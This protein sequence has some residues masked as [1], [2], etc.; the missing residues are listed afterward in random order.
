[1]T[2]R[3][4]RR[5]FTCTREE[6]YALVWSR[7]LN[8]LAAEFG[9]SGN[10][11]AKICDRLLVPHPARGYWSR[12]GDRNVEPPPL[13]PS[14]SPMADS[15]TISSERAASRRTRTRKPTEVRREQII[16]AAAELVRSEGLNALS[17]KRVAQIVGISEALIYNYFSSPGELMVVL[18][19][20]ELAEMVAAQDTEIAKFTDYSDRA[21]ASAAGYLRY[22]NR[23]GGLLQILLSS[24]EV[25]KALRPEYEERRVWT[26]RLM[27]RNI[28]G[29]YGLD[30]VMAA[31]GTT[32]LRAVPVR[33]GKLLAA[34]E[35]NLSA[36]EQITR[37][38]TN[39]GR[40]RLIER[41]NVAQAAAP[42]DS[43]PAA[44]RRKAQSTTS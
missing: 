33:A 20:I 10:A 7:P 36:A 31:A 28:S 34:G 3:P 17:M 40:A 9:I 32:M 12:T 13:P 15:V 16:A 43:K 2:K 4:A 19:R 26:T 44:G 24:P 21:R 39:G 5:P 6:L 8:A 1:M 37:A 42:P 27:A 41:A 22:V 25:R 11:L 14:P 18:A 29:S 35:I 23:R 30:P 38:I